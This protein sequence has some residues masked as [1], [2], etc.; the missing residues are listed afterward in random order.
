MEQE[1]LKHKAVRG[2]VALTGRTVLLQ[3]I[4]AVAFFLLGVFLSPSAV[5]VFIVV[6][7]V[8]RI[9]SLFTGRP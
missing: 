9:F 7:S 1:E 4:S 8:L 3:A 5:G 2:I 6:S